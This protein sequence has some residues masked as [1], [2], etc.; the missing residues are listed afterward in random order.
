MIQNDAS[1][2]L[3][4]S[5][6]FQLYKVTITH[7]NNYQLFHNDTAGKGTTAGKGKDY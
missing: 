2:R 5:F 1:F 6:L 4:E 7:T 3:G